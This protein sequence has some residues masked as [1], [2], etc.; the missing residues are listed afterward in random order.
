VLA[1]GDLIL[2]GLLQGFATELD[3]KRALSMPEPLRF[4]ARL[5]ALVPTTR[6]CPVM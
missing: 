4:M 3:A 2:A 5:A 1:V 6:P